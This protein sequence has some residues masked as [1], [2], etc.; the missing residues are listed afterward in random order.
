MPQAETT[1][2]RRYTR[3]AGDTHDT[4]SLLQCPL[5]STNLASTPA[6]RLP[7]CVRRWTRDVTF[8]EARAHLGMDTPRQWNDRAIARTPPARLRLSSIMTL[9]APLLI[10]KGMTSV[11]STA[12]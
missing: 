2:R 4:E 9:H 12:W 1:P 6:Q 8:A 3:H 7:W 5:L 11:R 10:E